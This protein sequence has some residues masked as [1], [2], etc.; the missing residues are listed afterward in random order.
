[1]D[2]QNGVVFLAD[3][4]QEARQCS[5]RKGGPPYHSISV[6]RRRLSYSF[7]LDS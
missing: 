3:K 6:S 2:G 4:M 5:W 1:M 7:A